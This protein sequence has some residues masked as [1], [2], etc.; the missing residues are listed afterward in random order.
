ME[1]VPIVGSHGVIWLTLSDGNYTIS[2]VLFDELNHLVHE[3]KLKISS[4]IE[5][6][7]YTVTD[8]MYEVT[9]G[10]TCLINAG[11][12]KIL[13]SDF[14]ERLGDPKDIFDAAEDGPR[15]YANAPTHPLLELS[16]NCLETV[17]KGSSGQVFKALQWI[18]VQVTGISKIDAKAWHLELFDGQGRFKAVM[19]Q[20]VEMEDLGI[21]GHLKNNVADIMTDGSEGLK[22]GDTISI[23]EYFIL[24][25]GRDK[26]MGLYNIRIF[27]HA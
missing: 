24:E 19:S 8:N 12:M 14:P 3:G 9:Q 21:Q 1:N 11:A 23:P 22:V 26:L 10:R 16:L 18:K 5:L 17:A 4:I 20:G 25:N 13:F 15:S 2:A 6:D 7:M 27:R